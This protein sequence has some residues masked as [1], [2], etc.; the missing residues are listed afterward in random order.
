LRDDLKARE[1]T[2]RKAFWI[3]GALERKT[4]SEATLLMIWKLDR[5]YPLGVAAGLSAEEIESLVPITT[6]EGTQLVRLADIP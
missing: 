3:L 4:D 5:D 1:R 2:R 6:M